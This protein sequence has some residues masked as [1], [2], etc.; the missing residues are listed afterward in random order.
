[1][2]I[3]FI[4]WSI[5]A[6]V[7]L[8]IGLSCRKSKEPVGFFTFAKAPVVEDVEHYNKA[9]GTL[10]IVAAGVLEIIGIPLLV[11]EQNSPL[12]MLVIP[13]VVLLII[14]MSIV[15]LWIEAKHKK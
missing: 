9:V 12:A 15:Y 4:I 7:F 3:A 11:L 6:L 14:L 8:G 1:M 13:A 5:V 10:W 2:I